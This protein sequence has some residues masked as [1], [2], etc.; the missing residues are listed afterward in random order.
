VRGS[1]EF[2]YLDK[3][4]ESF[5]RLHLT[6][7]CSDV[8]G[9]KHEVDETLELEEW[10]EFLKATLHRFHRFLEE[11]EEEFPK[12]LQKIEKYLDRIGR[13]LKAYVRWQQEKDD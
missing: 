3:Q 10:W 9:E 6:G 4:I 2:I 1:G 12:R 13:T 7:S 5:R 11:W 8:L